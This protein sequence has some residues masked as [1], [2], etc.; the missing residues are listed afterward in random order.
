MVIIY[1]YSILYLTWYSAFANLSK[2]DKLV[3]RK[4]FGTDLACDH[5]YFAS[6]FKIG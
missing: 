4:I 1:S 3:Q 5:R 6:L 2:L